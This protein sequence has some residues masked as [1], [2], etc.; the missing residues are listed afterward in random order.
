MLL[1][2]HNYM[3]KI[4]MPPKIYTTEV[5]IPGQAYLQGKGEEKGLATRGHLLVFQGTSYIY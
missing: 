1:T 2:M 4:L 5:A 3:Y